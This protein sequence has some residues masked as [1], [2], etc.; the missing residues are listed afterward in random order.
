MNDRA[1]EFVVEDRATRATRATEAAKGTE[2]EPAAPPP[3]RRKSAA[4][5]KALQEKSAARRKATQDLFR[6]KVTA[7][8]TVHLV[9]KYIDLKFNEL[10]ATYLKALH[11]DENEDKKSAEYKAALQ[12]FRA[13]KENFIDDLY[14]NPDQRDNKAV[15]GI[16][17]LGGI[18]GPYD[19][20][21]PV[22]APRAQA[23]A[24]APAP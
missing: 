21:L 2:A 11:E 4:R 7:L 13:A 19:Q 20:E 5:K 16:E 10:Y 8:R 18:N 15:V 6:D 12:V 3:A 24:P 9:S 1:N 22:R 23:L 14:D 17:A